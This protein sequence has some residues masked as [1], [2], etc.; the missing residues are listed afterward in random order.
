[1]DALQAHQ[2][3]ISRV[4]TSALLSERLHVVNKDQTTLHLISVAENSADSHTC[5]VAI[6]AASQES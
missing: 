1:M 5:C 4:L 2:Q 3:I 6:R